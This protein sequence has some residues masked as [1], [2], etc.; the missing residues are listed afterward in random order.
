MKKDKR[1]EYILM[2]MKEQILGKTKILPDKIEN[3]MTYDN[4]LVDLHFLKNQIDFISSVIDTTIDL[5]DIEKKELE[6][7]IGFHVEFSDDDSD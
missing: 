4:Y 3:I 2:H 7:A 1:T 6:S 5:L